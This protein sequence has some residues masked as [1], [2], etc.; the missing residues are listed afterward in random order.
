MKCRRK[1]HILIQH[2]YLKPMYFDEHGSSTLRLMYQR[3]TKMM[4]LFE[5]NQARVLKK[6]SNGW[7]V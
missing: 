5:I 7:P 4:L 3:E 1:N 6:P 2:Q